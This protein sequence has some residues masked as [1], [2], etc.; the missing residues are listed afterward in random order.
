VQAGSSPAFCDA[1]TRRSRD[2]A[3]TLVTT[4][5][6]E[7]GYYRCTRKARPQERVFLGVL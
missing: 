2:A 5:L 4:Q 7:T 1:R 3:G 6:I